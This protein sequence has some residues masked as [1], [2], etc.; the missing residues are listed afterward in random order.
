MKFV[1]VPGFAIPVAYLPTGEKIYPNG[2][3]LVIPNE[4]V[5]ETYFNFRVYYEDEYG[6]IRSYDCSEKWETWKNH[7][8]CKVVEN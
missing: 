8:S 1:R 4:Y 6:K 2:D 3:E 5:S 7:G